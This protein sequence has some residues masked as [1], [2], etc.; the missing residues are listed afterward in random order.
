MSTKALM[1]V[2]QFAR[3]ETAETEDYEL[4]EGE[5]VPWSSGT[6]KHNKIRDLL[7]HL[8]WSYFKTNPI[9]EAIAKVDCQ[10]SSETV[11]RP[12]VAV[13]LSERLRQIDL[14]RIPAPVAPDIAIEVLSPSERAMDVRRKVRDY[15]GAGTHEVWLVDPANGEVLLHTNT[16]IQVLQTA[17]P[18][19]SPRLPGFA[20]TVAD[21]LA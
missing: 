8:L 13:F 17:D 20:V 21:L 7:G 4:V 1:T 10:L 12:D 19:F 5:L 18:V 14:D 2:E 11:R 9:G 15:L 6:P 16:G 3:M